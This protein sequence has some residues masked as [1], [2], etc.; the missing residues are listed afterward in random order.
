MRVLVDQGKRE[1][2]GERNTTDENGKER[3]GAREM[4][5]GYENVLV[6]H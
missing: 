5:I 2:E 1:G 6:F 3:E 4:E